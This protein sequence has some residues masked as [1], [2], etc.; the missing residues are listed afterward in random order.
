LTVL[1]CTT[2]L[3]GSGTDGSRLAQTST[4]DREEAGD[5]ASFCSECGAAVEGAKFCPECGS[6][7]GGESKPAPSATTS[8][9]P[10]SEEREV[11][12]GAP[13]QITSPVASRTTS[14][15]LTT[16]RLRVDSGVLGR[17]SDS[18]DLFRVK[19]VQVKKSL[20]QRARGK[21]DVTIT[22]TDPSTPHFVLASVQDPDTVAETLRKLVSDAR[23]GHGVATLENM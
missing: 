18:L 20:A 21:G 12:R 13:D 22:S 19:D 8:V 7:T 11:W 3:K 2:Y 16:E 5:M 4:G 9:A 23:R 1:A 15:V 17:K 6:P 14:Y 10:E